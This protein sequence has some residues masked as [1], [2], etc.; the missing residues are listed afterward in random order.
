[1]VRGSPAALSLET[2]ETLG[3]VLSSVVKTTYLL[4]QIITD[5]QGFLGLSLSYGYLMSYGFG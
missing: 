2:E 1:M 3:Q 4:K 5:A